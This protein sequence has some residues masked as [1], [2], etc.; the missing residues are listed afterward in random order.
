[1]PLLVADK[2]LE[3]ANSTL[4]LGSN[5]SEVIGPALAAVLFGALGVRGILA[6][7]A[8]T[9]VVS[10]AAIRFLPVLPRGGADQQTF[11][12]DARAGLRYV[13]ATAPV[14]II[15]AGFCAVVLSNGIDD[16]AVVF[17]RTPLTGSR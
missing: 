13:W 6:V 11:F 17:L 14:R 9:F 8:A 1:M 5:S 12:R 16:V 3:G 7:D 10:A 2:D 4:G 15:V